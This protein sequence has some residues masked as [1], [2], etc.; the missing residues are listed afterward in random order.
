MG[1]YLEIKWLGHAGQGVVTAAS[2]FA[3]VLAQEGKYVQAFHEFIAQ[4]RIPLVQAFN[5]LSE[6]PIKT[7][8]EVDSANIVVLMD[9]RLLL[10]VDVKKNTV[11]N[12]TYIVN[13]SYNPDFIKEKLNLLEDNKI[14]TLDADTIANEEIG[15][16]TPNIPLMTILI[17]ST[18]LIP[19]ENYRKR[20]K[21]SLS[22]KFNPELVEVNCA[23]IVRALNEVKHL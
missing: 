23:T 3:E 15:L 2:V 13:T 12:A 11:G 10:S 8:A 7:H 5:R 16:A 9:V 21:E 1:K 14:W 4:K 6:S 20:L 18:G 17:D 19:M 22:L